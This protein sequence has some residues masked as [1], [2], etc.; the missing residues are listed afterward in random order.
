M[1]NHLTA[2]RWSAGWQNNFDATDGIGDNFDLYRFER[3]VAAT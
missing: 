1:D 2:I 3:H